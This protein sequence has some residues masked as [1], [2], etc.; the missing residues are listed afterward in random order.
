[1][2]VTVSV[3][4]LKN[5][6]DEPSIHGFAQQLE[7]MLDLR[8]LPYLLVRGTSLRKMLDLSAIEVMVGIPPNPVRSSA[9]MP[10]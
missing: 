6:P 2:A 7:S 4:H 3:P 5:A 9:L 10:L 1:M 8:D